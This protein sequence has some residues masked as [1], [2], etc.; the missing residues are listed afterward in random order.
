[1]KDLGFLSDL[2]NNVNNKENIDDE[3][4]F[5]ASYIEAVPVYMNNKV[6]YVTLF[7]EC[8]IS[9][10]IPCFRIMYLDSRGNYKLLHNDTDDKI[11]KI[12]EYLSANIDF[13]KQGYISIC[14]T[15]KQSN[16]I[17]IDY[18]NQAI[19]YLIV[20]YNILITN[21]YCLL[22]KCTV[23]D[24]ATNDYYKEPIYIDTITSGLYGHFRVAYVNDVKNKHGEISIEDV[25]YLVN[26]HSVVSEH[27]VISEHSVST[28]GGDLI[29]NHNLYKLYG[30]DLYITYIDITQTHIN[31][32][33]SIISGRNKVG[34]FANLFLENKSKGVWGEFISKETSNTSKENADRWNNVSENII[35]NRIDKNRVE[36][37]IVK[38]ELH[39]IKA[40]YMQN[41]SDNNK[42]V[43][44][45][46]KIGSNNTS[47]SF[48]DLLSIEDS[49][50]SNSIFL[51]I[52]LL[53][54]SVLY[55]HGINHFVIE[56]II[57]SRLLDVMLNILENIEKDCFTKQ[58]SLMINRTN[59]LINSIYNK[60]DINL[61]TPHE[62]YLITNIKSFIK[63]Y[64]VNTQIITPNYIDI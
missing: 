6:E 21:I 1:M 51:H 61:L 3:N 46:N 41:K 17:S 55:N 38:G 52:F 48:K 25:R 36:N 60:H 2:L 22:K 44:F 32:N 13:S 47:L 29:E 20:S 64:D 43:V 37:V 26:K 7:L 45:I 30:Y 39:D 4:Y 31:D 24:K 15:L 54:N 42:V 59:K 49:I 50:H 11:N 63:C 16:V 12:L 62:R 40:S 23:E 18:L 56:L 10:I 27:S 53:I 33:K 5:I 57:K 28:R 14:D 8:N 58:N 19:A 9:V 34:Y 35:L